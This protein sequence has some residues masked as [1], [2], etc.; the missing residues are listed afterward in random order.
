[1]FLAFV[2]LV[3]NTCF[4]H[5]ESACDDDLSDDAVKN[6]LPETSNYLCPEYGHQVF[7]LQPG[8]MMLYTIFFSSV[9]P[10]VKRD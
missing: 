10:A 4:N 9:P 1:M 3:F 7:V 5:T 2:R 8:T 6:I